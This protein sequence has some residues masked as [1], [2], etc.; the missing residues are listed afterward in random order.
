[1]R[2][3]GDVG[4]TVQR[5]RVSSE[6]RDS[7]CVFCVEDNG[8]GIDGAHLPRVFQ[9]FF[10]SDTKGKYRGSGL[11]LAICQQVVEQHHGRIWVESGLG[12][13][14]RFYFTLPLA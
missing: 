3:S 2:S 13:G 7:E 9:P 6:M 12:Q 8:I 4:A 10:R 14:S 1:M 5:I 11:G